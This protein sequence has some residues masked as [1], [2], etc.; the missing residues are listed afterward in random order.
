V[1]H[2]FSEIAANISMKDFLGHD[3]KDF[4]YY[5]VENTGTK[6]GCVIDDI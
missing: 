6:K 5:D 2:L 1:K 3:N 4:V